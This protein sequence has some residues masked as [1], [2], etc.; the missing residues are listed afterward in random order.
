MDFEIWHLI[1]NKRLVYVNGVFLFC[2]EKNARKRSFLTY[3]KNSDF[4]Q[5]LSWTESRFDK[6]ENI[7]IKRN[8]K[9]LK[10]NFI[11]F[12][13]YNKIIIGFLIIIFWNIYVS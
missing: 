3:R 12:V 8:Q 6:C 10:N 1:D 9:N 2:I 13:I 11:F 7:I 5:L 4:M